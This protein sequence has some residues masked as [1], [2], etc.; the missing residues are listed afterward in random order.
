MYVILMVYFLNSWYTYFN[1]FISN[2]DLLLLY[3]N[4]YNEILAWKH[5]IYLIPMHSTVLSSA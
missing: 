5:N 1:M 2:L 4:V 3:S